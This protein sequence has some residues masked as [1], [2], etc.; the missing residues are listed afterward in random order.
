MSPSSP[1]RLMVRRTL[2]ACE[3]W[4]REGISVEV[5]DPR[6]VAPLD[7]ETILQSVS[8]DGPAADRGRGVRARSAWGRRSPA[9]VIERGLRRPRR[10]DSSAERRASRRR[11]TAR[12]WKR[13]SCHTVEDIERAIR[14]LLAE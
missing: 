6:T 9:S 3:S 1:W 7:G 11:P 4:R 5:I 2:E 13:P 14:Q 10:A 12:R 8:Q